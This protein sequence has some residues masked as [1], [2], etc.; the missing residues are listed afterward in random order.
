[1][2]NFREMMLQLIR[3]QQPVHVF[4]ATVL[5][6]DRSQATIDVQPLEDAA[7]QLFDV[8]LRAVEDGT[9]TGLILW[10]KQKSVVL[11]GLIGNDLNTAYLVACSEV[12]QF[13][14]SNG[15]E[16]LATALQDLI[17]AIKALT[18]TTPAGVSGPPI[19]LPAFEALAQRFTVLLAA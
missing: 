5:S 6:I 16:S 3:E 8:Q 7:P 4:P 19:N 1:M 13:T 11:V 18:V 14:L 9:A 15:T 12:E 2:M 17:A 10:P